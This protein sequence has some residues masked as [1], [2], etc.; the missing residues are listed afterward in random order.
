MD[1]ET[2]K[3]MSESNKHYKHIYNFVMD[4]CKDEKDIK[5]FFEHLNEYLE[6]EIE[7]EKRCNE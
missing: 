4:Y 3:L 1:N 6:L 5:E 7:I 2:T